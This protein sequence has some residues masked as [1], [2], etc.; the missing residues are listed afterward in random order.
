MAAGNTYVA[1]ATNTLASVAAS[2]TFSSISG[3][4]TD[5]VLV[6]DGVSATG[7]AYPYIN[8]NGDTGANYSGTTLYGDGTSAGSS[9]RSDNNFTYWGTTAVTVR[10]N[11]I[12]HIMNYSNS[13]TYKT[14]LIRANVSNTTNAVV[15]LWRNTAAITS[16]TVF[17]QYVNFA[18]GS[19][20]TLYG[21]AA[22]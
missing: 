7:D 3:A 2:V 18:I 17:A 5:L 21:I 1:L 14:M 4:Y 15:A 20:F 10:N 8:F 16:V 19:T 11:D 9:R 22:A 6:M 13:T 12:I